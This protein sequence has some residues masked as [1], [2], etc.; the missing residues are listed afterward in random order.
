MTTRGSKR[1]RVLTVSG[2]GGVGA[3]EA[4]AAATDFRGAGSS[5]HTGTPSLPARTYF[6]V[7]GGDSAFPTKMTQSLSGRAVWVPLAAHPSRDNH[8]K[9]AVTFLP[10]V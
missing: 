2:G 1:S 8:K 7:V 6:S 9:R 10:G 5:S 3:G 4:G